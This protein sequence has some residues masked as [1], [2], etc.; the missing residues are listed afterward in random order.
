MAKLLVF[1]LPLLIAVAMWYLSARRM[2]GELDRRSTP[3]RDPR[4]LAAVDRLAQVLDLPRIEVWVYEIAPINGLAAPDGR[5]AG[6]KMAK[7][8][9]DGRCQGASPAARADRRPLR[10]GH[11]AQVLISCQ[12]GERVGAVGR[13]TSQLDR[14]PARGIIPRHRRTRGRRD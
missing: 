2:A 8:G 14:I 4:L 7:N 5:G 1:L 9:L 3:L 13:T 11:L 12:L 6:G 10:T